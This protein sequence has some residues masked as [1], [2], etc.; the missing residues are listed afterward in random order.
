MKLGTQIWSYPKDWDLEKIL[1]TASEVGYEGI[2]LSFD[3][4]GPVSLASTKEDLLAVKKLA[5][6]Y[7]MQIYSVASGLYWENNLVSDDITTREKAKIIVKKHLEAAS[8]LGAET[9]LV[10]PGY[11]NVDF[12]ADCTVVEYDLA[13]E[14]AKEWV[15]E[16][17]PI[18]EKFG[19]AIG[20]ENV[21][22]KF[23][24]SPIEMRDFIDAADSNF[25]AS[26]FDVGNVLYS[27]FPEHWIKILGK[28]IKK[29]HLKDFKRSVGTL[30]GFVNLLS[31]DVNFPAVIN[32]LKAVG[33]DGWLTTEIGLNPDYP[34]FSLKEMY[35]TM[36]E[37]IK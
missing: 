4:K 6:K 13:Y 31:G 22:N 11:V 23:L 7:N 16:L 15:N 12:I 35:E 28:R 21:W 5:E 9:I 32:A 27:G 34:E 18:A 20:I 17:K 30:S 8:I 1:K 33:Y 37:F 2:E 3:E 19:V 10:V 36:K 25:V 14:R 26:Y 24:L 29:V